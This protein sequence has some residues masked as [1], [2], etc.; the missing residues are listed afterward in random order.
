MLF[1]GQRLGTHPTFKTSWPGA[2]ARSVCGVAMPLLL[3]ALGGLAGAQNPSP[4]AVIN[5]EYTI[6]AA[7]LYHFSTYVT[8]PTSVAPAE[9][10]A[11]VI[12]VF[13]SNPFGTALDT[14]AQTKKVAGHPIEI[15]RLTTLDGLHECHIL[16]VPSSVPAIQ[17]DAILRATRES[18]VFVVGE[19][20][21]FVERGG[22]A[23]FFLEGNKV[24]FA[25][26][27]VAAK[28]EDL[29]VSSKLLALATIK[30][31]H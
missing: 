21:G 22:Q 1:Y 6:K 2:T 12:G 19:V 10:K 18:F 17:Q 11:F 7:F 3:I 5:R 23:Q 29:K 8:W 27:D 26:S 28:R 15:R 4:G 9:G 14:I 30:P 13:Q 31:S 24:R 20:D 16:F 25:V